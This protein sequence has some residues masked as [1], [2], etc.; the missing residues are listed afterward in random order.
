MFSPLNFY[1]G[2]INI[3]LGIYTLVHVKHS[4]TILEYLYLEKAGGKNADSQK[5]NRVALIEREL[6][7]HD[8]K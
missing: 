6:V 5:S 7:Y 4:I 3:V 1:L 8:M 2:A